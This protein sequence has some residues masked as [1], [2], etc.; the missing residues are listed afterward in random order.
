MFI[1]ELSLQ[2]VEVEVEGGS[3]GVTGDKAAKLATAVPAWVS[4]FVSV[5]SLDM[6]KDDSGQSPAVFVLSR[7]YIFDEKPGHL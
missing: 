3:G 6:F 5:T 7:N 1:T 2:E 4:K